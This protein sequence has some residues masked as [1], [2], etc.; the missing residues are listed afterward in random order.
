MA[1]ENRRITRYSTSKALREA[2]D[3]IKDS[4]KQAGYSAD[5]IRRA[6]R[7][8]ADRRP[9]KIVNEARKNSKEYSQKTGGPDN[10][11]IRSRGGDK[12]AKRQIEEA[13]RKIA[14][15]LSQKQVRTFKE[16]FRKIKQEEQ[17]KKEN[18][19]GAAY[20]LILGLNIL[21]DLLDTFLTPTGYGAAIFAFTTTLLAIITVAYLYLSGVTMT[22][23]KLA[24]SVVNW[25]IDLIG[26]P[27]NALNLI[28]I[29]ILEHNRLARVVAGKKFNLAKSISTK[30]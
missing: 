22:T 15:K 1:G 28:I 12:E 20:W 3:T 9:D 16:G 26:I 18:L 14:K 4:G 5:E 6:G 29:R 2:R 30:K 11:Y 25:I 7:Q 27:T 23:R 13:G 17:T 8:V 19:S 21:E 24:L 10:R